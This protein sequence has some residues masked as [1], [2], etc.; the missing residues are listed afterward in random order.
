MK[1]LRYLRPKSFVTLAEE[2]IVTDVHN[3]W[4]TNHLNHVR[5]YT[6]AGRLLSRFAEYGAADSLNKR[7]CPGDDIPG[8]SGLIAMELS[9][10]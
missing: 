4:R 9:P 6:K 10:E 5:L 2:E 7:L 1:A 3:A 8:V